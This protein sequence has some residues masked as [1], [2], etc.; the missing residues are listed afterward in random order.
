MLDEEFIKLTGLIQ[1]MVT[2]SQ[3]NELV[4]RAVFFNLKSAIR[5]P[6]S[7]GWMLDTGYWILDARYWMLDAGCWI[8]DTR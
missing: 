3:V 5:N 1:L 7:K 8:L 6:Q 4:D 2:R